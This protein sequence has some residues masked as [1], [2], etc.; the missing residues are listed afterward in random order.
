MTVCIVCEC[1]KTSCHFLSSPVF[2]LECFC[3]DCH[4]KGMHFATLSGR[5]KRVPPE[6]D[7]AERKRPVFLQYTPG[8]VKVVSGNSND[9]GSAT[10]EEGEKA[11]VQDQHQ[12]LSV[13]KCREDSK[14][15]NYVAKCCSSLFFVD[16]PGYGGKLLL[17]IPE[18]QNTQGWQDYAPACGRCHVKDWPQAQF[19][20][21]EQKHPIEGGSF[22][23]DHS[24]EAPKFCSTKPFAP[25]MDDS[26]VTAAGLMDKAGAEW[27][28]AKKLLEALGGAEAVKIEGLAEGASSAKLNPKA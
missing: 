13:N 4:V 1:G 11:G 27:K 23:L 18:L 15:I 7:V 25:M 16:Y 2:S 6:A 17:T 20:E 8:K 5:V 28:T 26:K 22:W 9:A 10:A 12:L 14:S 19:E 3:V 21:Y 24:G